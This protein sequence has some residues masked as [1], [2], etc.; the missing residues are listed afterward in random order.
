MDQRHQTATSM[1]KE[2]AQGSNTGMAHSR[3]T[4]QKTYDLLDQAAGIWNK[5]NANKDIL[6]NPMVLQ[7]D[8][9]NCLVKETL[10]TLTDKAKSVAAEELLRKEFQKFQSGR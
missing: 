7:H 9:M 10:Q 3:A 6:K 4:Q 1:L 8:K 2:P 5:E